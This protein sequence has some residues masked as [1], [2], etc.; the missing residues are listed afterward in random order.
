MLP[1]WFCTGRAR[2]PQRRGFVKWVRSRGILGQKGN[3]LI[4][5]WTK[6]KF[7]SVLVDYGDQVSQCPASCKE[8]NIL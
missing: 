1:G 6:R 3:A 2:L 5:L 8:S 4:M 7:I